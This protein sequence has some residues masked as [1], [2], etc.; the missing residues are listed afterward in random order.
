[1]YLYMYLYEGEKRMC[2]VSLMVNLVPIQK[3]CAFCTDLA[4]KAAR[5][6]RDTK[7]AD[8]QPQKGNLPKLICCDI[9]P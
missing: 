1:M 9:V 5:S 4:Q 3:R 6:D 2:A 7:K 8:K